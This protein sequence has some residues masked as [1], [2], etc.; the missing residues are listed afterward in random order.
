MCDT[1][2]VIWRS[3]C[4]CNRINIFKIVSAP[5]Q[6]NGDKAEQTCYSQ[7]NH[8]QLTNAHHTGCPKSPDEVLRGCIS[9]THGTTEMA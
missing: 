4:T 6:A 5:A 9:G 7:V 2:L 3:T 8:R 1:G